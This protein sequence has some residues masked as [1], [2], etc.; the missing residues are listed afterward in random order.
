MSKYFRTNKGNR[1]DVFLRV[2]LHH[3]ANLLRHG[4]HHPYGADKGFPPDAAG[5]S[6]AIESICAW[7]QDCN[8]IGT[9]S[10]NVAQILNQT[11]ARQRECHRLCHSEYDDYTIPS[12]WVCRP[13][14]ILHGQYKLALESS[15]VA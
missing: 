12:R 11:V 8:G 1:L 3:V 10:N 14:V 5:N 13:P 9:P 7:Q 4:F 2:E 15:S 6:N